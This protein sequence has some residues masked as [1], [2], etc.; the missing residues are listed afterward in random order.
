MQSQL[1]FQESRMI[2][3]DTQRHSR[4]LR[5]KIRNFFRAFASHGVIIFFGLFFFIPFLW[6]LLTAFKSSQDVSHTP[7]RLLPYDYKYVT[8]N[9]EKYPLYKVKTETG[10]REMAAVKIAEGYGTFVDPANPNVTVEY[11]LQQGKERIA[12]AIMVITFRWQNFPDAMK[13]GSRPT[14]GTVILGIFQ[15]QPD[16]GLLLHYWHAGIQHACGIC[17]CA[18]QVPW[19]ESII[20]PGPGNHDAALPGNDDSTL[21]VVQ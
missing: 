2:E 5:R 16:R 15:E 12:E 3:T 6:M 7:P 17:F 11:K 14:V 9:G 13:R 1:T 4:L 19:K 8:V 10:V 21:S 18:P 20:H